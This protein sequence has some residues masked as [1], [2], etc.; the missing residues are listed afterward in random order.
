[1]TSATR[2]QNRLRTSPV[3]ALGRSPTRP[4]RRPARVCDASPKRNSQSCPDGGVGATQQAPHVLALSRR[5]NALGPSG[6]RPQPHQR[7]MATPR[8]ADRQEQ[9]HDDDANGGHPSTR[10]Q[11]VGQG[12]IRADPS[13]RPHTD[14]HRR[15]RQYERR[16]DQLLQLL[17]GGE[18][19]SG[20]TSTRSLRSCP[21]VHPLLPPR[22]GSIAEA[23]LMY[24]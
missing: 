11:H 15:P 2:R 17:R 20:A 5:V 16:D 8:A 1:M 24:G 7:A 10:N 3:R 13:K 22:S 21:N 14:E 12:L 23:W 9:Y 19:T 4:T 18:K 6:F